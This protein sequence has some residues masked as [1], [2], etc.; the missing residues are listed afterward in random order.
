LLRAQAVFAPQ[1]VGTASAAQSVTVTATSAGTVST[2]DILTVGVAG[3]DFARGGGTSTCA[4]AHLAAGAKCTES[5]TFKPAAPG[6]RAGAVVLLDGAGKV[7]GTAYLSGT[8]LG[9]LG[10][11]VPANMITVAGV[12]RTWTSTEDGIPAVDANLDQPASVTLDGAGNMYI[13]DT[14]HNRIRKVTASTGIISTI[15]G[16]S[17]A[18]YTGDGGPAKSA[19]LDTPSSV[20]I[21]GAGDIYIADTAN[22]AVRKI[23]AATGIMS[24]VAGD[25]APGFGGDNGPASA[26]RLSGP[27]GVSVDAAGNLYIADTANQRIRKVDAATGIIT[28]VA[29]NGFL[30]AGGFGGYSGDNGPAASAELNL[31]YAVAFDAAGNFYIPDSANSR[32]RKVDTKGVITTYAG[33]GIPGDSGD[34]GPATAAEL[35]LPL[36]VAVDPAGNLYIADTQN[37]A[38][39]K[40]S[41]D[42]PNNIIT[43]AQSG[44]GVTLA[45]GSSTPGPVIL[46]APTGIAIDAF[47]NLFVADYYYMLVREIQSNLSILNF[48]PTPV[49]QEDISAPQ[50]QALENDGNAP[51][52]LSAIDP[53]KNSAVD[54]AGTTCNLGSPFLA[55]NADCTVAAEFAPTS[56]GNPL[57]G[58][59]DI[60]GATDNSPLVIELLGDALAVNSTTVTLI[61]SHNPSD[62]GQSVTFTATVTTGKGTGSLTGKVTFYDGTKTLSVPVAVNATGQAA[63]ATAT[64]SVGSHS[65]TAAYS[66]DAAHL[67]ATSAPLVQVVDEGTST[68]LTSSQNP[69]QIGASVTFTATVKAPAGAG[70]VPDGTVTFSDGATTLGTVALDAGG[71]ATLATAALSNGL[72]LIQASYSGDPAK[73]ILASISAVL[74]QE[75]QAPTSIVLVSSNNP[76][77]HGT[78]VTFT[79]TVTSTGS[80]A[81]SGVVAFL[82]G[83]KQFAAANLASAT[84]VAFVTTSNLAAGAHSI[85]AVYKG[86]TDDGSSVSAPLTQVVTQTQTSTTVA[87]HPDPGIAGKP[88]AITAIVKVTQGSATPTGSVTFTDRGATLGSAPLTASG[89]AAINPTLAPGDH[90]IVATYSGDSNDEGSASAPLALTIQLAVTSVAVSATP[91]PAVVL[92]QVVIDATVTGNGGTPTGNVI[93]LVDGKGIGSRQLNSAG[94]ARLSISTLT[95]GRHQIT[96]RYSGDADNAESTSAAFSEVVQ[97]IPT[98]TDLGTSSIGSSQ[99]TLVATVFGTFGPTPSGTVTFK[100][101]SR[102]IGTSALDS[103]GVASLTPNLASGTYT[104]VAS[105]SGDAVHL[106]STSMPLVIS[107]TAAGFDLTVNPA[108]LTVKTKDSATVTVTLASNSGFTD[109]IGLGCGSVPSAVTCHFSNSDDKLAANGVDKIQLTIDTNYPLSGGS[110]SN[111]HTGTPG[112]ESAGFLLPIGALFGWLLWRWRLRNRAALTAVL[113]LVLSAAALLVSGCGGFT[114]IS[115][116]PGN[117]VIQVTGV[118]ANS[119]ITHYQNVTLNITQ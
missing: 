82:D 22:N 90:S 65:I 52:D 119:N 94:L 43:I 42:S 63:Y 14:A 76:S 67:A 2:I 116:K 106:P 79:A 26:A 112:V 51:L 7:L 13:A 58:D 30:S 78:P 118:G 19:T 50:D 96:A 21:D 8:G 113:V 83:G 38:I 10:V 3:L 107:G 70:I 54:A 68:T 23:T 1:T 93:F 102:V 84:G 81:A 73:L 12:Y 111:A 101:G 5:V 59:I 37:S 44:E 61:S 89:T 57:V 60:T 25:G 40:V 88:V 56:A 86:S 34:S 47:G 33:S 4:S 97:A 20:A 15:A 114:Q 62:Y 108:T 115:A 105:Y 46:Y 28:T 92:S 55:V 117:Y 74:R 18:S 24:T 69:S 48:I 64:L 75:V 91:N 87:A 41:P 53:V 39:R 32:I 98:F 6:T 9:G 109:T 100:D 77:I 80:I 110:A 49:R 85:T 45:P 99:V 66:G 103:S 71:V 35:H 104:I 95:V 16:N 17:A 11:F 29:G 72:H 31:P 36:G 27:L